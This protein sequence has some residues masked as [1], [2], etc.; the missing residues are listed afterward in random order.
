M[1]SKVFGIS[2]RTHFRENLG[3]KLR[4]LLQALEPEKVVK[5]KSIWAIK[6]H[7]GER[8][9]HTFIRP[10]LVRSFVDELKE[11]GGKPFLTDAN[12][13]YVGGRI[14]AVDHLE[15]A[16]MHGFGYEVTGAPLIIS[17][18]LR[19]AGE[20]A[21]DVNRGGVKK[22]YISADFNAAD[23]AV[24]LSHLKG[25]E[26]TGF[27]GALKNLGMGAASRRGK[28]DQHS[29]LSPQVT[30]KKC[31]GCGR[32]VKQCAHQAIDMAKKKAHIDP[33]K[34]VGCANCIPI[35]PQEAIAVSWNGDAPRFMKKMIEY[36]KAAVA[37]KGE[38]LLYVNF[39]NGVSPLCDC[40]NH[41]DA[42]IVAD[43][44][45]LA[46]R[47]PVALDMASAELVNQAPG[48]SGSALPESA[49]APGADKWTALHPDCQ[50][51][52][53]LEY[54]EKIGLGSCKYELVW[55]PEVAGIK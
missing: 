22:A 4:R 33:A 37:G 36:S 48:L 19:G 16:V 54:A 8:G 27:G 7:F 29:D 18:G 20:A 23:G 50:W 30:S 9:N 1:T 31:V 46:S 35:C 45:V 49:L 2:L 34:C 11:L 5:P 21:I 26:L 44:G 14:N 53:Q 47:D 15:T 24:I 25:H 17:D 12:T 10:H 39:V 3:Q 6:I 28:L 43:L 55:L 51:R 38:N 41:S 13:L 52:F 32:C 42:P 40:V